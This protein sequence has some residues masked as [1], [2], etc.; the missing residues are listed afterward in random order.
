M[1]DGT[2]LAAFYTGIII[3]MIAGTIYGWMIRDERK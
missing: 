3:G 1:I 2:H